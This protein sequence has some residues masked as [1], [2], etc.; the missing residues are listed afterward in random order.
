MIRILLVAIAMMSLSGCALLLKSKN[1]GVLFSS[2]P[3][4][5]EVLVNGRS[6]GRTPLSLKLKQKGDYAILFRAEGHED[7]LVRLDNHV[8]V[9]WL[10]LD[11]VGGMIPVII[12][13][14]SGSWYSLDDSAVHGILPP[15][16]IPTPTDSVTV[17]APPVAP[18]DGAAAALVPAKANPGA[19]E[20]PDE[21]GGTELP[22][23]PGVPVT[24]GMKDGKVFAAKSIEP[25]GIDLYRV[26]LTTGEAKFFSAYKIN[27][28]VTEDGSDWT[29]RVLE[30]RKRVP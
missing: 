22:R 5:A 30:N 18:A 3:T 6:Y 4:G 19:R 29:R 11:L 28:V 17:T 14:V 1:K 8:G 21:M 9:G 7:R 20:R 2:E 10:L 25:H 16:R 26:T 12:D 13:G 24:V 27:S 15:S 23:L